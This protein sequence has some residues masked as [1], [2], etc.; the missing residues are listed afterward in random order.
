[1]EFTLEVE[2]LLITATMTATI[3]VVLNYIALIVISELDEIYYDQ[4]RSKL[5]EEFED[6][7]L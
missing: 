4:V 3:E 7:E 2:S 5:K 1:V 6:R